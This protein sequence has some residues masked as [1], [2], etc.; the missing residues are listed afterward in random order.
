M[1]GDVGGL[2]ALDLVPGLRFRGA[3]GVDFDVPHFIHRPRPSVAEQGYLLGLWGEIEHRRDAGTDESRAFWR[4]VE[5]I[6]A[7]YRASHHVIISGGKG[8][9]NFEVQMRIGSRQILQSRMPV[10]GLSVTNRLGHAIRDRKRKSVL[11]A[12][13]IHIDYLLTRLGKPVSGDVCRLGGDAEHQEHDSADECIR[14]A[15]SITHGGSPLKR[16]SFVWHPNAHALV[17]F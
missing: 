13:F 9:N 6:F 5:V 16:S 1:G 11:G 8:L 4:Q 15:N 14:P 17:R 3:V 2:V 10:A 12:G 7:R